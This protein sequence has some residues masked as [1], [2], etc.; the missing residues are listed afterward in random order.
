MNCTSCQAARQTQGLWPLFN[1]PQCLWCCARLIQKIGKLR[2][3]T[4]DEISARRRAVLADACAWGHSETTIRQLA[5]LKELAV[6]PLPIE[7]KNQ[8]T[9]P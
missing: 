6:E 1:C 9:T 8:R 3:P 4:S 7:T 2:T 5:K